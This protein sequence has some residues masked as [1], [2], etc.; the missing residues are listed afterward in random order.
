MYD[1][2]TYRDKGQFCRCTDLSFV[3][4]VNGLQA[5]NATRY[6]VSSQRDY[7]G[8]ETS[9]HHIPPLADPDRQRNRVIPVPN[10]LR[11]ED[12]GYVTMLFRVVPKTPHL[13]RGFCP[14]DALQCL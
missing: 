7:G 6:I 11:R 13:G 2:A 10:S 3:D 5:I 14:I 8:I 12:D 4:L 1:S 9:L